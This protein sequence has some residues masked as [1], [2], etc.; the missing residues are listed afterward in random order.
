M[1]PGLLSNR[2]QV[3]RPLGTGAITRVFEAWDRLTDSRVAIKVPIGRFAND[4]TLLVRMEREVAGLAGFTHPNV[5]KV[6]EVER[7]GDAGFI[8]TEL[9]NGPSLRDLFAARGPLSPVK[10]AR[11][12]AG[13]CAALAAA[14]SHGIAHGHLTTGNVFLTVDGGVKVTDF[15]LAEATRPFPGA[16]D[17]TADLRALGGCLVAMLTGR[18]PAEG[19]PIDLGPRVPPELAAVVAR[20]FGDPGDPYPS[21]AELG[22][23]LDRFV[24]GAQPRTAPAGERRAAT[25]EDPPGTSAPTRPR[26]TELVLAPRR[27]AT[28][29]PPRRRRRGLVIAAS[30]VAAGLAISGSFAGVR[31]LGGR[32]ATAVGPELASAASP[33]PGL[34]VTTTTGRAPKTTAPAATTG[35]ATTTRPAVVPASTVPGTSPPPATG[36]AGQRVVPNVVGLRWQQ[37]SSRLAQAQ[38]GTRV[39]FTPAA[40]SSQIRRVIS[41]QP[42]AGTVVPTG[43]EVT[44]LIGTKK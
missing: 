25:T 30:L 34:V 18:E 14:H 13:V 43:S 40:N 38:L 3:D 22:R 39:S 29:A 36:V 15:R 37:A 16:P 32:Q 5:A 17:P 7:Q 1:D 6:H 44:V 35:P 10:A 4:K 20:A 31:L 21:A 23:D 33:S 2:Y 24:A 8:V 11:A 41:Q 27:R 12:A 9:V 28:V 26:S 19:Q 42:A